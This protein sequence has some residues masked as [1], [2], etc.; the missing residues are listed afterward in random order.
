[1]Q[2]LVRPGGSLHTSF[3][4]AAQGPGSKKG[5][6]RNGRDAAVSSAA[7]KLRAGIITGCFALV[8]VKQVVDPIE[9]S[10]LV[11]VG[12]TPIDKES[13]LVLQGRP[14]IEVVEPKIADLSDRCR[15]CSS[16]R[17]MSQ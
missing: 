8:R 1:M 11:A 14:F 12:R 16:Q 4:H 15:C 7:T 13:T 6:S 2:S 9:K 3:I 17:A 5:T 10:L